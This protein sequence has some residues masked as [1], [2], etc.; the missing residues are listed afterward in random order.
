MKNTYYAKYAIFIDEGHYRRSI[1]M[2]DPTNPEH[3]IPRHRH[4]FD[5]LTSVRKGRA[6]VTLE[7]DGQRVDHVLDKDD[8][9][10]V[11]AD[12]WHSAIPLLPRTVVRCMFYHRDIKGDP[13]RIKTEEIPF[14]TGNE[15]AYN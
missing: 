1:G 14:L 12:A 15:A 6:L 5:H 7:V 10:V 9:L 11:P 4:N 8:E 13:T 3:V 2:P